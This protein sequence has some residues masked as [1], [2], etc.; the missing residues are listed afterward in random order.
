MRIY[1]SY[2]LIAIFFISLLYSCEHTENL[3]KTIK[4]SVVQD[5]LK[6]IDVDTM[7]AKNTSET[8]TIKSAFARILY[9]PTDSI[10]DIKLYKFLN[11]NIGKKCFGVKNPEFDCESFLK[12]LFKI[13]YDK[14]ISNTIDEQMKSNNFS[15]FTDSTFLRIGDILFFNYSAKQIDKISHAGLYLQN[16]FFVLASYDKGVTITKFKNG[17][18]DKR[19]VAAGRMVYNK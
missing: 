19:F 2:F 17:Y 14:E 8:D 9:L 11:D 12:L 15:L 10:E 16:G 3:T 5:T 13:V 6:S 1:K 7:G 18:W 4:A